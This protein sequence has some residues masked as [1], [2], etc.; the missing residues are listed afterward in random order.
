M[1]PKAVWTRS[2]RIDREGLAWTYAGVRADFVYVLFMYGYSV[3][4]I[5]NNLIDGQEI[6]TR[7]IEDCI[8]YGR[9]RD[10]QKATPKRSTP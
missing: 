7:S 3:D 6:P 4:E 8:R 10:R 1:K 2:V 9:W 5:R